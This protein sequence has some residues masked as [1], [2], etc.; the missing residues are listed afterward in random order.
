MTEPRPRATIVMTARER[1]SLAQAAIDAVLAG[2]TPP[3]R[4][5][6][7]DVQSPAELREALAARARRGELEVVRFDEP[8]WPQ[9]ARQRIAS[10][11]DTD[12]VVFIDNDVI[13]GNG[14]LDAL[15]ACAD[16]TGAGV[17]GPLYLIGDGRSPARV[18]MAGGRLV[19]STTPEGR[20]LN[21]A[22]IHIDADPAA[23]APT[24][25]RRPCDFVEY[26]CM[27]IRAALLRDGTLLDP[28]ICCVHEHIDTA[29]GVGQRGHSV[30]VEPAARVT[31]LGLADY[32][33]DEIAF[34]RERWSTAAAESSIDAF[35]RKWGV[36]DDARSF[37][38]AR[39]FVL[40]HV[41]QVDLIRPASLRREDHALACR[42]DELQQTRSGLID[43][44]IER[45]YSRNELAL[46]ANAYHVA[47]VL[48]DGGY[49]PCGRPFIAHLVGTA[50]VL[51]RYGFRAGTVAA[52]LLHA[53]YTH[54][55]AHRDGPAGA[56]KAVGAALGGQGSALERRVRAYAMR[57]TGR[58][59]DALLAAP[60]GDLGMFDAE[61]LAIDAANE[62]DMHLSGEVRY[63]GRADVM[64]DAVLDRTVQVCE[65]LGVPGL[66]ST[67]QSIRAP[68]APPPVEFVT[69]ITGSY[70]IGPDRRSAVPMVNNVVAQLL[71]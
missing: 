70:R 52:G 32:K 59:R 67:L 11:I 49:R 3:Y 9:Q 44:A 6:Y 71:Q 69:R 36:V 35:C 15:V 63:S 48:V 29:L 2:T 1:H 23:V 14:W 58:A 21:E 50:S 62:I 26:H 10:G 25:E 5:V 46:I 54:C 43:A 60:V 41:G 45:G 34:Y 53:A 61:I 37:A 12:Y 18:H 30:H 47:H 24:L 33:L 65:R 68:G 57:E 66:G 38:G 13:V 40:D 27:L 28:S 8:L 20:I 22:H 39:Q 42:P 4:F 16:E 56:V 7:L 31:Y 55:P 51:V 19:E 17:V 64:R